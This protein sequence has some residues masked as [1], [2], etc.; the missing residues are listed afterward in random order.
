MFGRK[1]GMTYTRRGIFVP[2]R[3][4]SDEPRRKK[5]KMI[6]S[7]GSTFL[8][9]KKKDAPSITKKRQSPIRVSKEPIKQPRQLTEC[10]WGTK[11]KKMKPHA[12]DGTPL[13][14]VKHCDCGE[15]LCVCAAEDGIY[16]FSCPFC[17]KSITID[18]TDED[19]LGE[20]SIMD[21]LRFRKTIEKKHV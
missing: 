10:T 5:S 19:D 15:K 2:E 18:T 13:P 20:I 17:G 9:G 4:Y 7:G 3:S 14:Y 8:P 16:T 21:T 12:R 11:R 1:E 6:Y